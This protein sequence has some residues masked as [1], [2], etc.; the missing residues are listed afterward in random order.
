MYGYCE[1]S[2]RWRKLYARELE[3]KGRIADLASKESNAAHEKAHLM[4]ALDDLQYQQGIWANT[5]DFE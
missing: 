2:R 1:S 4:G 3:L 5:M